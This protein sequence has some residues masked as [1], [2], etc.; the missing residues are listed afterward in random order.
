V[1]GLFFVHDD[2]FDPLSGRFMVSFFG[3]LF[4]AVAGLCGSSTLTFFKRRLAFEGVFPLLD[5]IQYAFSRAD[6]F[7]GWTRPDRVFPGVF[8]LK[9]CDH[10]FSL[11]FVG[12]CSV[13][14]GRPPGLVFPLEPSA[15]WAFLGPFPCFVLGPQRVPFFFFFFVLDRTP[16]LWRTRAA[17]ESPASIPY[18]GATKAT[19]FV[20]YILVPLVP[21]GHS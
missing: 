9:G 21:S 4:F 14:T 10:P 19:R 8:F 6:L 12:G 18:L 20:S 11:N 17:F 1:E 7:T 5:Q 16:A 3:C 15:W 13:F 2:V